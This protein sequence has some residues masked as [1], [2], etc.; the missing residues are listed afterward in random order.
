MKILTTRAFRIPMA[1]VGFVMLSAGSC[2]PPPPCNCNSGMDCSGDVND[3]IYSCEFGASCE[4]DKGFE[5]LC[6]KA[7]AD[8]NPDDGT[9]TTPP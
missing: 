7:F 8:E 2:I 6:V 3:V 5:G 4:A 1:L 9:Q